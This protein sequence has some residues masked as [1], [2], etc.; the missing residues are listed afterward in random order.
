MGGIGSGNRVR[1]DKR[2]TLD[3]VKRIDIRYLKKRGMLKAGS[4]GTLSWTRGGEH[5]GEINYRC[6]DDFLQ[7]NFRHKAHGSDW[8]SIEQRIF[9]DRKPCHYG[10]VRQW[11]LCPGCSERVG[12]L[13]CDD[14]LFLCRHCYQ[15]PYASQQQSRIDRLIDQQHKL[16]ERIFKHYD[17]GDG[18]GKKKGMH[19]R[20]YDRL[21]VRYQ[22]ME[23]QLEGYMERYL[24]LL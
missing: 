23:Q 17:Y 2:T 5:N 16:G 3:Q 18:W 7:L 21:H 13:C 14:S 11:F 24:R 22:E 12:I 9:F 10:G 20:T 4:S 1:W 8:Q 15:L 6:H 19:W